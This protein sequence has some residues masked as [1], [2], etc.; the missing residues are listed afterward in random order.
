[1]AGNIAEQPSC[2]TF[3]HQVGDLPNL[4]LIHRSAFFFNHHGIGKEREAGRQYG[5]IL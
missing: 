5:G 2:A 1:V 4:G 3:L